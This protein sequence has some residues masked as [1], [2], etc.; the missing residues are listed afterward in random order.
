MKI[1]AKSPTMKERGKK[2]LEQGA[3]WPNKRVQGRRSSNETSPSRGGAQEGFTRETT[4]NDQVPWG[5]RIEKDKWSHQALWPRLKTYKSMRERLK[6][7]QPEGNNNGKRM[8]N[9]FYKFTKIKEGPIL[10]LEKEA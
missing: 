10:F 6:E 5:E 3:K 8:P 1:E 2:H 4:T 9:A 7:P